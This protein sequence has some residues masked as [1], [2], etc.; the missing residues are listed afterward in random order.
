M[1]TK[2]STKTSIFKPN[3]KLV[4]TFDI[5]LIVSVLLSI[6][7]VML[8]SISAVS[9]KYGTVLRF[10]E[11]FFTILF[12]IEYILRIWL[13]EKPRKYI[14]SFFGFVDFVSVIPTYLALLQPISHFLIIIRILR[15]LRVFR[16]LKLATYIREIDGL[17]AAFKTSRRRILVF[18]VTV[19]TLVVMLGAVMYIIEDAKAGFTSIPR[20]IYWAIVTLT[21]VGYGDISPQSDLGQAVAAIIMI[22]G[23]SLIVVPTGFVSVSIAGKSNKVC[24]ICKKNGHDNTAVFCQFCSARLE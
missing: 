24:S 16:V 17:I 4:K 20:S 21:T 12:T 11:W 19:L 1:N 13:A 5:I 8:E 14:F 10:V 22:L 7:A 2:T 15:V 3:T 18:L 23:Y 9:V 6:G